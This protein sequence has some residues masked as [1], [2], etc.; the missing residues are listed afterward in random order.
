MYLW[1]QIPV[2]DEAPTLE[3]VVTGALSAGER[4]VE[5]GAIVRFTVFVIDDGSKDGSADILSRLA[6]DPRVRVAHHGETRG[7]GTGFRE[8]VALALGAGADALVHIDADGQFDPARIPI[9]VDTLERTG[10]DLVT[11]SRFSLGAPRP[12]M[13]PV[14][15]VGNTLLALLVSILV[16][17]RL[18]DVACGFRVFSRRALER[19]RLSG[20]FT[21]T[22]ESVV[23]C[24]LGG[25]QIVE[26]A[27]PVRGTRAFGRS[28]I[29]SR[30]SRY[31]FH[32]ALGIA[33]AFVAHRFG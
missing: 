5:R 29:S 18:R 16:R 22:H 4:L 7:L 31:A 25:L 11:A 26:V 12:V 8:G 33:R 28:R 14:R 17:Q 27:L 13:G 23:S 21:Y 20:R 2:L 10:A 1:I 3:G 24:A 32:A 9:L 19:M 30:V 6:A 15:R